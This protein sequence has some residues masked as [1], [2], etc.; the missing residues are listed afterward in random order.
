LRR[1]LFRIWLAASGVWFAGWLFYFW[2][3]CHPRTNL[4]LTYCRLL[5]F[6]DWLKQPEYFTVGDYLNIILSGLVVPITSFIVGVAGLWAVAGFKA[7]PNR[8]RNYQYLNIPIL[9]VGLFSKCLSSRRHQKSFFDNIGH[10]PTLRA[11]LI[12][13]CNIRPGPPNEGW[14]MTSDQ[15]GIRNSTQMLHEKFGY[16]T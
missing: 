16:W 12:S 1:G 4:P 11:D 14:S 7:R 15:L 5:F 13:A 6:D 10:L 2:H 9:D 3:T 8:I